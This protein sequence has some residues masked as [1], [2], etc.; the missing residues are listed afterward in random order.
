M[1]AN[2][3]A[4]R[5]LARTTL[6]QAIIAKGN[7]CS[8]ATS[9]LCRGGSSQDPKRSRIAAQAA[10]TL[11]FSIRIRFIFHIRFFVFVSIGCLS[12]HK[13]T[14]CRHK[15]PPIQ[16]LAQTTC[17]SET[18]FVYAKNHTVQNRIQIPPTPTPPPQTPMFS[19]FAV[20]YQVPL[21]HRYTNDS[22]D[23]S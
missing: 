14:Y 13:Q 20:L 3:I 21:C 18:I 1:H 4:Y 23:L 16:H 5:L 12:M 11:R 8:E 15:T 9:R 7:P 17:L 10:I 22:Y 19:R 6:G 2:D